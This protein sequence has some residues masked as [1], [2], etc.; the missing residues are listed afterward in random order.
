MFCSGEWLFGCASVVGIV[1]MALIVSLIRQRKKAKKMRLFGKGH[2]ARVARMLLDKSLWQHRFQQS[3]DFIHVFAARVFPHQAD[4]PN[5]SLQ[6][7]KAR[8]NF[9]IVV[10]E[11][12]LT[13]R[14]FVGALGNA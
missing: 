6:R 13:D 9:D 8:A 5:L 3:E 2:S 14:S 7:A 4:A 10:T 11:Q 1:F 12:F